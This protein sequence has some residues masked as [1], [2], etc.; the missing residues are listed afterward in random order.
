[1]QT[2]EEQWWERDQQAKEEAP[3]EDQ[4]FERM[5]SLARPFAA[6]GAAAG[7]F[8]ILGLGAFR[9]AAREVSPLT[10]MI[11]TAI[12][13]ALAGVALRR[14]RSLHQA[15]LARDAVMVRVG[16]ITALAGAASG[17][18]VGLLTW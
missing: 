10:P 16:A 5:P 12:V 17:G 6:F 8:A 7:F 15:T 14:W 4:G 3:A 18:M 1:M 9:A 13:G 2:A 11:T